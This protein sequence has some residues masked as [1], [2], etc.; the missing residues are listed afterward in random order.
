MDSSIF[1]IIKP[2]HVGDL[3]LTASNVPS[4]VQPAYAAGITYAA[5]ALVS[6]TM[7]TVQSIYKSLQA[8]NIGHTPATSPTW[9]TPVGVVYEQYNAATSYAIGDVVQMDS[10]A[11][12]VTL[13]SALVTA[14]SHFRLNGESGRLSTTGTLPP[15]YSSSIEYFIVQPTINSF[16]LSLTKGGNPIVASSSGTG[17]HTFTVSSHLLYESLTAANVGNV[18]YKTLNTSWLEIGTINKWRMFDAA[19]QSRTENVGTID[20][21]ITCAGLVNAVAVLNSE[22]VSATITQVETGYT[23]TQSLRSHN[24]SNWY[25]W[26]FTEP[27]AVDD[28]IFQ[29]I[30][31]YVGGTLHVV[32][33]GGV[34][35]A[36]CGV[37]AA[38]ELRAIGH[39]QWGASRSINDYSVTKE[40]EWGNINLIPRSFSQRLRIDVDIAKGNESNVTRLLESYRATPLVF[41][42]AADYNMTYLYGFL[43]PW[44]VPLSNTNQRASIELK[45]LV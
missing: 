4:A 1:R 21:T 26:Y 36:K 35:V 10:P 8:G 32:I 41:V 7:G 34:G 30:P 13:A 44:S 25:D 11:F 42:A 37:M 40:D 39:T 5:G 12:T 19:Y 24:V 33:D 17:T 22:G 6:T 29:D 45:G 43:G 23:K 14:P 15:E 16:K 18:P 3:A 9:W 28:L 31:P 38:G 27:L 2:M 20:T